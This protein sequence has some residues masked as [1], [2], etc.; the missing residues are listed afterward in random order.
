MKLVALMPISK[1]TQ[2]CQF[3]S[4]DAMETFSMGLIGGCLGTGLRK[5]SRNG[6]LP[7]PSY[8]EG[9]LLMRKAILNGNCHYWHK[10]G[11]DVRTVR[12]IVGETNAMCRII[13]RG[14]V[15]AFSVFL[16]EINAGFFVVVQCLCRL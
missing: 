12:A 11:R 4:T 2:T 13:T 8:A 3:T 5:H 10:G 14:S 16:F 7:H 6:R 9:Q 1:E 15:S